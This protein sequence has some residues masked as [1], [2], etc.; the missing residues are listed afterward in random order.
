LS[1]SLPFCLVYRF[2]CHLLALH[3]FLH[4]DD[5]LQFFFSFLVF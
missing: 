4:L 2:S 1:F 5:I 3:F